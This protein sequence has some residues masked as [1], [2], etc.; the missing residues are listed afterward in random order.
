MIR[1]KTA[2]LLVRLNPSLYR[3]CIWYTKKDIPMLF[4]QIEK[5]LYE[6]LRA[7]LLFYLPQVEG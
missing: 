7:T 5:A 4:V 1:G 2:E 6:M 3:P